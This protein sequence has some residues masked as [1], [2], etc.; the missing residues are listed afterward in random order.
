MEAKE[1]GF[2]RFDQQFRLER[3]RAFD[4]RT[5]ARAAAAGRWLSILNSSP[6]L[7]GSA[8]S[9]YFGFDRCRVRS[10]APAPCACPPLHG[11]NHSTHNYSRENILLFIFS[12]M[13]H[14][15]GP[16]MGQLRLYHRPSRSSPSYQHIF[17][18]IIKWQTSRPAIRESPPP[19]DTHNPR[20]V[21]S[22][23]LTS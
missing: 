14:E 17:Y 22:A 5:P 23:L 12:S 8:R 7:D 2:D 15:S 9:Y 18:G 13:S 20:R 1:S 6:S 3:R 10:R 21:I 19:M 4:A 11:I 16:K